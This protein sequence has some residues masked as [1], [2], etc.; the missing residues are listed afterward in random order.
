MS[1]DRR[2]PDAGSRDRCGCHDPL[3]AGSTEMVGWSIHGGRQR[4][5]LMEIGRDD[6]PGYSRVKLTSI[7][8]IN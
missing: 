8:V 5:Y 6:S 4:F 2:R 7:S 1:V 3:R